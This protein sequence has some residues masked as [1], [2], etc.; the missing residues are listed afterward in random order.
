[1]ESSDVPPSSTPQTEEITSA[2]QSFGSL[3]ETSN[4]DSSSAF[5][6]H[7][8]ASLTGEESPAAE[9]V[10]KVVPETP[11]E[12]SSQLQLEQSNSLTESPA[13]VEVIIYHKRSQRWAQRTV[14]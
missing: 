13:K 14:M 11:A 12:D 2:E 9:G 1:M 10:P 7:S 5:Q 4:I 8:D 6:S 3:S